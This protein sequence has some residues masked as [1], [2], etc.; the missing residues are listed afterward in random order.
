MLQLQFIHSKNEHYQLQAWIHFNLNPN[1]E[2]E[3]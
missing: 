1:N 3:K 2:G